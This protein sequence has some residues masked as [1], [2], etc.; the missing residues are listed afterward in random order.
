MPGSIILEETL[1]YSI[2]ISTEGNGLVRSNEIRNLGMIFDT[3]QS[4]RPHIQ[5]CVKCLENAQISDK[6]K[7]L[8]IS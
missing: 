5:E 7:V 2:Q 1:C 8:K 4:F 3:S 6:F